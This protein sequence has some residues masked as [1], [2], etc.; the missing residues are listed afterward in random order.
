M[1]FLNG[2]GESPL[3]DT[4]YELDFAGHTHWRVPTIDELRS[5]VYC[6]N[7]YEETYCYHQNNAYDFQQPT[8][9]LNILV[10]QGSRLS[11]LR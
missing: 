3:W 11:G 7:G 10:T 9:D 5:I 4:C 1:V 2:T 6:S 8:L